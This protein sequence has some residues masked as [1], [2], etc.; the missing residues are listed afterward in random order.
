[1]MRGESG[2]A[3]VLAEVI[4]ADGLG[5]RDE[6]AEDPAPAREVADGVRGLRVEPDMDELVE[7]DPVG[8]DDAERAILGIHQFDGRLDHATQHD[9][10][11]DLPDHRL[12]GAEEAAQAVLRGRWSD[13]RVSRFRIARDMIPTRHP[14][15]LSP[16]FN[17]RPAPV[18]DQGRRDFRPAGR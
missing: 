4:Q 2:R 8:G 16:P 3:R 17:L 9:R 1:M 14:F 12:D 11:F 6:R 7:R 5:V 15:P 13:A 18:P 10:Q